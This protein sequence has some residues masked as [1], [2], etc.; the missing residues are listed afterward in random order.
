MPNKIFLNKDIPAV[1]EQLNYT[2]EDMH[3]LMADTARGVQECSAAEANQAIREMMFALLELNPEDVNKPRLYNKAM[4]KNSSKLFEVIEETVEDMLEQGW[5][6]D[7]FF[8]RFVETRNLSDGD[9]N[10]FYTEDDTLLSVYRVAGSH[11]DMSIQRLGVGESYSVKTQFYGAKVA[12]DIRLYLAGRIDFTKLV[13][14]VYAAFDRKAKEIIY[15]EF[16]SASSN[17]PMSSY[18]NKAFAMAA[19]S[20]DTLDQLLEDVSAANGNKEVMIMGAP[21]AVKKL[22]KL[23]DVDWI[24]SDAKNELYHTGRLGYY[25]G[26]PVVEIPQVLLKNGSTLQR[27]VPVD[28]LLIMPVDMDKPVKF[29][30]VGDMQILEISEVGEYMDDQMSFEA[31]DRMGAAVVVGKYFGCVTITG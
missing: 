13:N 1:F 5:G 2:Y 10:E 11:H 21:A 16:A 14:A 31:Q 4:K 8:M 15:T 27:L 3:V 19:A 18:F 24:S 12:T 26:H 20:K 6:S 23:D 22:R 29:V 25:E 7:P 17:V 28:K 9:R 30:H